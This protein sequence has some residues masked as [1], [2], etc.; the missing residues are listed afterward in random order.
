MGAGNAQQNFNVVHAP[1]LLVKQHMNND[2]GPIQTLKPRILLLRTIRASDW[3]RVEFYGRLVKQLSS[4]TDYWSLSSL[5]PALSVSLPDGL[6]PNLQILHWHHS[7]NDFHY[8]HHFLRPTITKISLMSSSNANSSLFSTLAT[9]CPRLLDISVSNTG[10]DS[11]EPAVSEFVCNLQCVQKISVP[12]LDQRALEHISRLTTLNQL[13]LF[14]MPEVLMPTP[15]HQSSTFPAL[16][17]LTLHYPSIRPTTQFLGWCSGVPLAEFHTCFWE[18]VAGTEIDSFLAAI[19]TAFL[20]SSLTSLSIDGDC[21]DLEGSDPNIHIITLQSIRR[22]FTFVNLTELVITSL[23]GFDLDNDA[24]AELARAWPRIVTLTLAVCFPR[25]E[26]SVTLS[27]LHSF[28]QHCPHLR[29]LT[30]ALDARVAPSPNID[31]RTR[32]VQHALTTLCVEHSPLTEPLHAAR[33]LSGIFPKLTNVQTQREH[34]A[35]DEEQEQEHGDAIR[36]HRLWKRVEWLLPEL[37]AIRDEGM[38]LAQAPWTA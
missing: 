35:N 13:I 10:H 31:P 4:G 30:I 3:S 24:V 15:L 32:F 27:C 8:I 1:D 20:H 33:F 16:R 23:V 17:R 38:M 36:L 28:A 9:K 18:A 29:V 2:S 7:K 11:L 5:F 6:F 25:H 26:P 19:S 12:S 34:Y 14:S 21:D 37:S 22:I